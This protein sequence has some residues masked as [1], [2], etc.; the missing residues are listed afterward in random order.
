[1]DQERPLESGLGLELRQQAVYV[2]DV[3]RP[4]DLRDHD[5]LELVADLRDEPGDV[6]EDPWALEAVDPGPQRGAAEVDLL[7]HP[8]EP[9]AGRL[10]P[11][12][13][14]RVLEV[15]EQDVRLFGHVRHLRGHLLVARVEEVDHPRGLDRDL[16]QGLGSAD[17]E[18]LKEIAGRPHERRSNLPGVKIVPPVTRS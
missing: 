5:H 15:A 3:P 4:L 2:V 18:G 13:R 8:D 10:L 9:F 7:C 11:V 14:D 1:M 6:V 16:A 12:R 17:R